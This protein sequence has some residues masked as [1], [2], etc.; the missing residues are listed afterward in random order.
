M[1]TTTGTPAA[2]TATCYS[3]ITKFKG[4]TG[5]GRESPTVGDQGDPEERYK[6][7]HDPWILVA[8]EG[9]T[10]TLNALGS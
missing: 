3:A 2:G 10:W 8:T 5:Q 1:S 6:M 4:P 9:W 7:E